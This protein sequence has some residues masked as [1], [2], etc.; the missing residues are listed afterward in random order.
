LPKGMFEALSVTA[1][2]MPVPV[3][4]SCVVAGVPP[5]KDTLSEALS[6][7]TV[8]GVNVTPI[9]HAPPPE[10]RTVPSAQGVP[11]PGAAVLKSPGFAPVKVIEPLAASVAE[12]P[13]LLVSVNGIVA[14]AVPLRCGLKF[15]G[16]GV[17]A[18]VAV[19][20]LPVSI[21]VCGLPAASSATLT[22][23][24]LGPVEVGA[25]A[26]PI[27]QFVPAANTLAPERVQGVPAVGAPKVNW[28]GS[29]PVFEMLVIFS[30]A[31]PVLL[32]VTSVVELV[33][34]TG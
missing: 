29:L 14:L 5:W 24:P 22:F 16:E 12:L 27:L 4:L 28:V 3:K 1:G 23:A 18:T 6:W 9:V 34:L 32:S 30:D 19:V 7:P 25:K 33:V 2:N 11:V 31:S 10:A 26:T 20:P 15:A 13:P 17:R 21:T 8:L